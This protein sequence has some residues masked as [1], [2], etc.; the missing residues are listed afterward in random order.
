M[1]FLTVLTRAVL[2]SWL[3]AICHLE[4]E[5]E[6]LSAALLQLL[7]ELVVAH[8]LDLGVLHCGYASS[9]DSVR[10]TILVLMGSL[11]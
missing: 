5:V 9:P 3:V 4:A 7:G 8:G 2:S 1:S 11:C 6:E 10:A